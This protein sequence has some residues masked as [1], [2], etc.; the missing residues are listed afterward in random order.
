MRVKLVEDE[1]CL[2]IDNN[3]SPSSRLLLPDSGNM[4]WGDVV[5]LGGGPY[6]GPFQGSR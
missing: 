6:G 1:L 5:Y 3:K 2:F 4:D